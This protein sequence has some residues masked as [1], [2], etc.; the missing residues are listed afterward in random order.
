VKLGCVAL[1]LAR[2]PGVDEAVIVRETGFAADVL[3]RYRRMPLATPGPGAESLRTGQP[4]WVTGEDDALAVRFPALAALWER[5]QVSAVATVP[6][7]TAEGTV[8]A[9]S[10]TSPSRTRCPRKT[11]NSSS[12]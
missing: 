10:F 12:R 9:M 4:V 5:F 8:G 11:G 3:E 7:T 6:L 1:A 2:E